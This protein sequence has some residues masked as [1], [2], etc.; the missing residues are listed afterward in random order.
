MPYRLIIIA[1]LLLAASQSASAGVMYAISD[2]VDS[3]PGQFE[4]M[5]SM[6][7]SDEIEDGRWVDTQSNSIA[8]VINRVV[9]NAPAAVIGKSDALDLGLFC[10]AIRLR[11]CRLPRSPVIDGLLKPV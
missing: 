6:G 11:N 3:S 2:G 10:G 4:M 8:I 7:D 5:M 9:S 1:L